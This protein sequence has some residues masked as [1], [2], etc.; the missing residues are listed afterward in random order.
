MTIVLK[1]PE[2]DKVFEV[3]TDVS[4]FAIGGVLI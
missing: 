2:F 4:D 1:Y 3:Y